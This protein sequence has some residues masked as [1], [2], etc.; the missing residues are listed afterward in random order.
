MKRSGCS[1]AAATLAAAYLALLA[2]PAP[3]AGPFAL[4]FSL[5]TDGVVLGVRPDMSRY[6]VIGNAVLITTAAGYTT[7]PS[8]VIGSIEALLAFDFDHLLLGHG[9]TQTDRAYAEKVL[10][11]Q[12]HAVSEI[13]RL[14]AEGLGEESIRQRLDLAPYDE[15]IVQRDEKVRSFFDRWYVQ[16]I[17]GRAVAEI[18]LE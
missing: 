12:R 16:P 4:E 10:T 8:E 15:A 5:V 2:S 13:R 11:L 18:E 6:P 7:Y 14:H 1:H 17:V 9:P 3:A